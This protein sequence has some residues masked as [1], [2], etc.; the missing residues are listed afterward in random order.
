MGLPECPH[1]PTP[2]LP[3]DESGEAKMLFFTFPLLVFE[4][5]W[6]VKQWDL[7]I[8]DRH[9][10]KKKTCKSKLTGGLIQTIYVLA[11]AKSP[12][13]INVV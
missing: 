9:C 3:I 2:T 13:R 7:A 4:K 11:K 8:I 5:V 10:E 12:K 6:K 1:V